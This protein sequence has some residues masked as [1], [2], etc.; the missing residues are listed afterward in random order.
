MIARDRRPVVLAPLLALVFLAC[1]DAGSGQ[2]RARQGI[3][4]KVASQL[5]EARKIADPEKRA[6]EIAVIASASA[7]MNQDDAVSPAFQEAFDAGLE[8]EDLDRQSHV[9][10]QVLGYLQTAKRDDEA[11]NL[12]RSHRVAWVRSELIAGVARRSAAEKL[13][14][15]A[16]LRDEATVAARAEDDSIRKGTALAVLANDLMSLGAS[17]HGAEL[18][19]E[20]E[21][22]ALGAEDFWATPTGTVYGRGTAVYLTGA[23]VYGWVE[24]GRG[25]RAR[26]FIARI[27]DEKLRKKLERDQ[28]RFEKMAGGF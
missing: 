24:G 8:I 23:I 4:N 17:D 9:L 1:F 10:S 11:A 7:A 27:D 28:A 15:S 19:L 20:A 3:S 5:E 13:E 25:D 14:W 21:R 26:E 6:R 22:D 16:M 12:A 2:E 18:M